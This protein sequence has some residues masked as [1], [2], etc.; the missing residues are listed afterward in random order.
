MYTILHQLP[1]ILNKNSLNSTLVMGKVGCIVNLAALLV[2]CLGG[3]VPNFDL[4]GAV[5]KKPQLQVMDCKLYL[6]ALFVFQVPVYC[7]YLVE[8]YPSYP[9]ITKLGTVVSQS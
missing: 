9:S 4:A 3:L 7:S 2:G 5:K 1:F 8:L 6:E